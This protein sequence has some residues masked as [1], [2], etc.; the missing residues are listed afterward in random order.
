MVGLNIWQGMW[1]FTLPVLATASKICYMQRQDGVSTPQGKLF[2]ARRRGCVNIRSPEREAPDYGGLLGKIS[3]A[4]SNPKG[5]LVCQQGG[6]T[7]CV[8]SSSVL[9][10]SSST[11]ASIIRTSTNTMALPR[12]ISCR[13]KYL[14]SLVMRTSFSDNAGFLGC[15]L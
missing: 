2:Q 4:Y 13:Y 15:Y 8:D 9:G 1:T 11:P 14:R 3:T 6:S 12:N 10:A 7:F 5:P